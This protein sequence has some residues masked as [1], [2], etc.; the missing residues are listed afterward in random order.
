M[1][2]TE[3][4]IAVAELDPVAEFT[5]GVKLLQNEY[6]QKALACLTRA[7]ECDKQNPFYLSF[8]GLSIALA[9]RKWD[10]AIELCEMAIDK[11]RR[12]IQF[13]LNLADVY[14]AA[15]RR[16]H[17]L[18]TIDKA[19]ESLGEDKRLRN[20]RS[21]IA[22]RRSPVVPFLT[23]NNILNRELG[24]FRHKILKRLG[25]EDASG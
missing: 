7:F 16:E 3:S 25:K 10:R 21:R 17:A 9:E 19:L 18:F 24:R 5:E 12:E 4:A 20:A 8:L 22:K 13:H 14:A 6:P 23:R 2:Q 1:K 11:K 15:G